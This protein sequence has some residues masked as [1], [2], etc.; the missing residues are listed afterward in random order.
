MGSEPRRLM[1]W[2]PP[3]PPFYTY[4]KIEVEESPLFDM[5]AESHYQKKDNIT[6]TILQDFKTRYDAN[7]SKQDIFYYVYGVLHS[8]EYK[9]RFASDLKKMLP[10]IPF[11]QD[12]WAFSN[13]GRELANWHIHYETVEPYPLHETVPLLETPDTYRVQKMNFAKKG[14]EVD[15]TTL[16]YNSQITLSGIPLETYEYKVCDRTAIRT[17]N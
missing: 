15:K 17:P 8:P 11:V 7:I 2:T 4:E 12:F 10:R 16:H 3:S 6:D 5:P 13:A 1:R 14:K 9:Q